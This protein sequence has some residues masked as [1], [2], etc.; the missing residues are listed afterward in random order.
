MSALRAYIGGRL[1]VSGVQAI[2]DIR[3][4]DATTYTAIELWAD[5][6]ATLT[7]AKVWLDVDTRGVAVAIA[8]PDATARSQSYD[9]AWTPGSYTY[10]TP[11]SSA[12]GLTIPTLA[13][14][15]KTLIALRR[16]TSGGTTANPEVNVLRHDGA[17]S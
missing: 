13:P 5:L 12:A 6:A 8:V 17:W 3:L 15:N 16:V 10:S 11:T 4:G 1:V 14:G 9:W 7:G 2:P